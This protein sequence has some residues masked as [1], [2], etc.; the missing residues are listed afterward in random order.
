MDPGKG[1]NLGGEKH[2]DLTFTEV[3]RTEEVDTDDEQ[4]HN[5]DVDGEMVELMIPDGELLQVGNH[6][7]ATHIVIPKGDQN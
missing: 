1:N 2:A 4:N 7:R 3:S 6:L 5:C